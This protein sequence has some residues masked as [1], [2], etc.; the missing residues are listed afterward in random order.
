LF[1]REEAARQSE[2]GFVYHTAWKEA[3]EDTP[4]GYG[5]GVEGGYSTFEQA[6]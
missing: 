1:T 5:A 4:Q 6:V 3:Y 2:I